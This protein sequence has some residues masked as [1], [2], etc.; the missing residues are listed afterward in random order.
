MIEDISCSGVVSGTQL[1]Q[2]TSEIITQVNQNESDITELDASKLDIDEPE[3]AVLTINETYFE[4][5]STPLSYK[6]IQDRVY[7]KGGVRRILSSSSFRTIGTLPAGFRPN[8]TRAFSGV[9]F[10]ID[11]VTLFKHRPHNFNIPTSGNISIANFDSFNL[12]ANEE[13]VLDG[14]FFHIT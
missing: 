9:H 3:W 1:V 11:S 10:G 12:Q 8:T 7:F 6:K 13:L 2:K 4:M 5:L 14:C